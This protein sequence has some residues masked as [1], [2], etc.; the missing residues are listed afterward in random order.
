MKR[1]KRANLKG[2]DDQGLLHLRSDGKEFS[3]GSSEQ[4]VHMLPVAQVKILPVHVPCSHVPSAMH[5]PFVNHGVVSG[6][7]LQQASRHLWQL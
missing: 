1:V 5:A 4:H 6:D 3:C 7:R 2:S